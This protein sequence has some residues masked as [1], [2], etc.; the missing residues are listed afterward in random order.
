MIINKSA[1]DLIV[2]LNETD[3]TEHLEAKTCS[4]SVGKS[5]YETICAFS[6]E[7]DLGGGTLLLGVEKEEA[8]FPFYSPSGVE[9]PDKISSDLASACHNTFNIPIRIDIHVEKV[10]K[11]TVIRVNVPELPK[12]SKPL[13]IRS[14]GLPR[15]AY[16]RIGP[17][18]IR[19]TDEDMPIFFSGK[20]ERSYDEQIV[21]DAT[22]ADIDPKAIK[23][24]RLARAE[25]NPHAESLAWSDQELLHALGGIQYVEGNVKIT[26]TGLLMFGTATALRRLVP[27]HRVDYIRIPGNKWVE[28]PDTPFQSIDMRGPLVTLISRV[29]ASISDDLPKVFRVGT[30]STGQRQE[31][32][33]VPLR[34]LREAV[35]NSLMHRNY[36]LNRPV[37]VLRFGNRITI[38]NP[39]Y[40]LKNQDRFEESGSIIR[41]PRIAEILHETRFAETKGSGIRVMQKMMAE[42]GLAEPTFESDRDSDEFTATLLFHHFLDEDDVKWLAGFKDMDLSNEQLKALIFVREVGAISNSIYRSL[43]RVDTLVASKSLRKLRTMELLVETGSG[44]SISYVAG[45]EMLKRL[46]GSSEFTIHGNTLTMHGNAPKNL[47]DLPVS[48]RKDVRTAQLRSRLSADDA[49]DLIGRLC[50]WSELSLAEIAEFLGKSPSHVSQRYLSTLIDKQKLEYVIPEMPQHPNQKYRIRRI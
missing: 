41:N 36:Q 16:R 24:Y 22:W 50:E 49:M 2:L 26:N 29:M 38:K 7:P 32:P 48:L 47:E 10:G 21:R 31:T 30:A 3:E 6:N 19:C 25:T 35:V 13:Y 23:A 37:Q 4:K 11:E 12:S 8:L 17:T 44:K 9:D 40:S 28:D 14:T 1:K 5:V 27:S 20:A 46:G 43:S 45:P 33:V 18:D 15:G 34:V 39:G 42:S